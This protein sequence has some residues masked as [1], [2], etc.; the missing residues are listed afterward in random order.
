MSGWDLSDVTA[1]CTATLRE[2]GLANQP[3]ERTGCAGR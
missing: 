2:G 3:L 1:M